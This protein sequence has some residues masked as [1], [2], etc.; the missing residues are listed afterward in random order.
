MINVYFESSTHAELVA[1]FDSEE[2][3][4]ACLPTLEA[5]AKK[6]NMFVTEQVATTL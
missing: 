2:L 3:F 4:I 1:T 5:E 6:Q